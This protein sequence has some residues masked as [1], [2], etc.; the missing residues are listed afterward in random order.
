MSS[1]FIITSADYSKPETFA[2]FWR[3]AMILEMAQDR[4]IAENAPVRVSY[5]GLCEDY[6]VTPEGKKTYLGKV[7][8]D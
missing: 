7:I 3:W 6:E 5:L 1:G 4:A 2:G 8:F